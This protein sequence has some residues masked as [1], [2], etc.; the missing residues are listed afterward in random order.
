[1]KTKY[2][3]FHVLFIF[4]TACQSREEMCDKI[5]SSMQKEELFIRVLSKDCS[6]RICNAEVEDFNYKNMKYSMDFDQFFYVKI[7]KLCEAGDIVFKEK[8][9]LEYCVKKE[10]KN[11]FID[12]TCDNDASGVDIECKYVYK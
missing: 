5:T 8:G 1:M 3:I 10:S 4:F 9:S 7:F 12:Y 2:L 6:G 11:I